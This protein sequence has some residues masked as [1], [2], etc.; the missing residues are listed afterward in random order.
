MAASQA[1]LSSERIWR[2]CKCHEVSTN[3]KISA[4]RCEPSASEVR[5][6]LNIPAARWRVRPLIALG[7]VTYNRFSGFRDPARRQAGT[8][9]R[10]DAEQECH[11]DKPSA[12]F[13]HKATV[14]SNS[15]TMTVV[16]SC[17]R[18]QIWMRGQ[19]R[20]EVGSAGPFVNMCVTPIVKANEF[21]R[22]KRQI[23]LAVYIFPKA[24]Q[25]FIGIAICHSHIDDAPGG[26]GAICSEEILT[27][28][29]KPN[30]RQAAGYDDAA[31]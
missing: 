3:R 27:V 19:C 5:D 10:A 30:G 25:R 23:E 9:S 22:H 1:T 16:G 29:I 4:A 21:I 20:A 11:P 13:S 18:N 14:S 31:K 17:A 12:D 7:G 15:P 28:H 24:P 8:N 2:P 6:V 26:R